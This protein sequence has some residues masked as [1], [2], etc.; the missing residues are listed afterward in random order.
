MRIL[1]VEPDAATATD[2]AETLAAFGHETVRASDGAQA[3][4]LVRGVRVDAILME[5]A[6]PDADA[7]ALVATLRGEGVGTPL[8]LRADRPA[9]GLVVAAIDAGADDVVAHAAEDAELEARLRAVARRALHAAATAPG[10]MR[11]GVM[12]VGDIEVDETRLRA[13]RGRRTLDLARLEFRLLCALARSPEA[14]V[15]RAVLLREVWGLETAPR[16]NLVEAHMRRL[17]LVLNAGGEPDPIR[18]VRGLGYRL[19]ASGAVHEKP[20][21]PWGDPG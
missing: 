1:I 13:Q 16:A 8:L 9:A 14:V 17:R 15:T 2:L 18:T 4:A 6:L 19:T 5:R 11:S 21:P 20:G 12:R 3:A 7:L 10:A